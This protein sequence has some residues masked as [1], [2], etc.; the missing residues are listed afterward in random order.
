MPYNHNPSKLKTNITKIRLIG[1]QCQI[2]YAGKKFSGQISNETKNTW[3]ILTINGLRTIP[4]NQS[5]ITIEI[6]N[7]LYEINGQQLKGRHEDRIKRRIRR[8]W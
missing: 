1:Q 7:Q 3:Q 6:N 2:N 5:V 4:K 8:K